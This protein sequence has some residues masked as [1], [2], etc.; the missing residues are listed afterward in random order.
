MGGETPITS[1]AGDGG[2]FC[3]SPLTVI[4][5]HPRLHLAILRR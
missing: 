3:L 2:V 5:P 4:L 1:E